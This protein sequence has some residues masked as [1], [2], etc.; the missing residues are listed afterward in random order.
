MARLLACF[1][2]LVE[3]I[4]PGLL[5]DKTFFLSVQDVVFALIGWSLA[6]VVTYIL[7]VFIIPCRT[8]QMTL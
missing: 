6:G 4:C 2:S 7:P 5:V 8:L 3:H 1:T